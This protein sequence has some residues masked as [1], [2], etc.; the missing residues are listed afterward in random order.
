[1]D[2]GLRP[3]WREYMSTKVGPWDVGRLAGD[4]NTTAKRFNSLF[5]SRHA[6][7]MDTMAQDWSKGVSFILPGFHMADRIL[8]KL[9]ET[10]LTPCSSFPSGPTNRGGRASH[11]ARGARGWPRRSFCRPTF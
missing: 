2:F 10:A 11:Q 7:A 8:D 9:S 6:E 3:D 5:D 4:H 1:M